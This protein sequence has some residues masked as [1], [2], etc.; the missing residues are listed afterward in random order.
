[1][2]SRPI[3]TSV[4]VQVPAA[5]TLY[6]A[7]DEPTVAGSRGTLAVLHAVDLYDELVVSRAARLTVTTSG[8]PGAPEAQ[9]NVAGAAARAFAD[10]LGVTASV[11]ID[12]T[13]KI[14]VASGLSGASA[15]AAGTLLGCAMLWGA[16]LGRDALAEIGTA[17]RRGVPFAL[18]GGTAL[19]ADPGDRPSPVL[20]RTPLHWVLAYSEQRHGRAAALTELDR[21]RAERS[22]TPARNVRDLLAALGSGDPA[23][24]ARHLA[25]DLQPAAISLRP[26]LRQTLRA[27]LEAGAL[28][29]VVT[30]AGPTVALLTDSRDAAARI[31]A[32]MAGSGTCS[33]VQL[34]SGPVPGARVVDS[35]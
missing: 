13:K 23:Q 24:V 22:P 8:A 9:R 25:N 28:G 21:L 3:V 10:H 11:S 15:D 26:Q 34:A 2:T 7:V 1:M 27:G 18:S 33:A 35:E 20:A 30:G 12:I 4:R 29:A 5:V 14:P 17:I 19:A 6:L 32:E 31:A 16:D